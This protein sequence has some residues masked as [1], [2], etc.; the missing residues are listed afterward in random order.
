V[1]ILV[2]GE[3][4]FFN[5]GT[6]HHDAEAWYAGIDLATP[7]LGWANTRKVVGNGVD[8][9]WKQN[10]KGKAMYRRIDTVLR[11]AEGNRTD[12]NAPFHRIAYMNYF[13][14]PAEKACEAIKVKPL[15]RIHSASVLE[16]V[17]GII[18][19]P[20]VVFCSVAAWRETSKAH[21]MDRF[22]DIVEFAFTPHP[23]RSWW[24]RPMKTYGGKRGR[25]MLLEAVQSAYKPQLAT[26]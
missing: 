11:Q 16:V 17:I 10:P 1:K 9:R 12:G 2:L 26:V 19:P 24:N 3:S 23:T 13:Q 18:E 6:L 22:R 8:E 15:D 4:H 21:V 20:L 7:G 25:D 5:G 14:R